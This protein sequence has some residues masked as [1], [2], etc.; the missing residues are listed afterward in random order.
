MTFKMDIRL[1]ILLGLGAAGPTASAA[2][3]A[4]TTTTTQLDDFVMRERRS[5]PTKDGRVTNTERIGQVEL[6]RAARCNLGESFSTSPSVDVNYSDAAT[7]AKQI[8]L[9][10]LPGTYVQL[11]TENTRRHSAGRH[12]LMRCGMSPAT[13]MKSIQVSKGV[14]SV[15]NGYEAMTGQIDIEYLKPQDPQGVSLNAYFDSNL[16]LE[17]NADGNWHITDKLNTE[18]LAHF[19]NGWETT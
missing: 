14:A 13:W 10:G 7:G 1:M 4:D 15:K 3:P 12:R 5:H 18:V 6:C 8:K 16:K 17:L 9:L 19:E 11:L 2:E